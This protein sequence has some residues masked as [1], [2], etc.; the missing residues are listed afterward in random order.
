MKNEIRRHAARYIVVGI[1]FVCTFL[2]RSLVFSNVGANPSGTKTISDIIG[3]KAEIILTYIITELVAF[4]F[5]FLLWKVIF[6]I[7]SEYRKEYTF[8]L[9]IYFLGAGSIALVWPEVF[10]GPDGISD[11]LVTL[12]CGMRLTPD[13]WHSF[14]SSV[15]YA[16]SMLV[17]PV[18]YAVTLV[19]WTF[20]FFFVAYFF[21]RA[22]NHSRWM[23]FG[24]FI[25]AC[26]PYSID[27]IACGHRMCQYVI[28]TLLYVS[29]ILFDILEEKEQ[30]VGK[31]LVICCVSAFISV[32]RTE[33]IILGGLFFLLYVLAGIRKNIKQKA[34]FFGIYLILVVVVSLPQRIGDAKY[35]GKD[36]SIINSFE[37]L[38]YIF[39]SDN[40]VLDYDGAE[41]DMD[42]I[43][44]FAS[45]DSIKELGTDGYRRTNYGVKGNYDINQSGA[46]VQQA[47]QF[48]KAYRRIAIHNLP[49]C[50]SHQ[51]NSVLVAAGFA[52]VYSKNEY[53]GEKTLL[54]AWTYWGW[55]NGED[56]LYSDPLTVSWKNIPLRAR[57][58]NKF[59]RIRASYVDGSMR[60]H[61][62]GIGLIALIISATAIFIQGLATL[63]KKN[64]NAIILG[65]SA[66]IVLI[67]F[68]AIIAVM[69]AASTIY[70]HSCG[71]LSLLLVLFKCCGI[72]KR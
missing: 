42:A 7:V 59:M 55:I 36:Y 63:G 26:L 2:W 32:W 54:P 4:I 33:G 50:F 3:D 16:A 34:F 30:S 70:F 5:I 21:M 11:N 66:G 6:L 64:K 35:Y 52:P 56:D 62:F 1:H 46:T 9:L 57:I 28:L 10:I 15:I 38:K 14:Y 61:F 43:G 31:I 13:Y 53:T 67:Q 44:K 17:I 40:P 25:F 49:L 68:L 71:Y 19:Q 12:A 18:K 29:V 41:D 8:L 39:N 69:P 23:R 51:V 60:T 37:V 20:F 27:V 58:A 22:K 65:A 72:K 48:Q 45:I 24:V 47:E